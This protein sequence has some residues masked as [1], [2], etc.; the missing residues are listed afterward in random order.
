MNKQREE[1]IARYKQKKSLNEKLSELK[2]NIENL[3]HD[4]DVVREYFLTMIKHFIII[5]YEFW[6]TFTL[7][8]FH[9]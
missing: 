6:T 1:K 7:F 8:M 3:S 4:E 5:R 9:F 2:K